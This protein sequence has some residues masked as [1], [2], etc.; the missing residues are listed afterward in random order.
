MSWDTAG[1]G[2]GGGGEWGSG[3]SKNFNEPAN[4]DAGDGF[5]NGG[6]F[7]GGSGDAFGDAGGG[8]VGGGGGPSG[9]CFNCGEEGHMKGDCPNPAKPRPCYNCGEEGHT[10]QECTNETVVREFSGTCRICEMVG[11][12]ATDCP[13]KPPSICK[14]CLEEGHE[15]IGCKNPRKI[16]RSHI[17]DVSGEAAWELIKQ[18]VAERDLDD[19]KDAVDMYVKACPDVTY[20]QLEDAFRSQGVGIFLIAIEKEL[21]LTYTNMDL[22]GHLGKKYAISWRWDPKPRAPKEMDVWPTSPEENMERLAD[23][24]QPTDCKMPKCSNCDE[25]GHTKKSCPQDQMETE[26]AQVKCYNCDEVGHRVRDCPTPRPDKFACRNCKQSGHSSKECPEPRSAEGVECKKC[27][28]VGHFSRDCPQGG[29]GGAC[30][31]CG[32]TGHRKQDCTNEKQLICRNCDAIGHLGKECPL[33]R[34]Y[35]RVKCSNCEEMGHT[36]VRCKQPLK[37]E[38]GEGG[39]GGFNAGGAG[40]GNN[41]GGDDF[42]NNT[43]VVSGGGDQWGGGGGGG[44]AW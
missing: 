10:K 36:K 31:N 28:E 41:A 11:H 19:V 12:R 33:P 44:G 13:S 40:F 1:G 4:G 38:D 6:D 43:E 14:N 27:N 37:V 32:E 29:G 18:G 15:I 30:H 42:G 23:A 39:D 2:G 20:A 34:D 24:G 26:R 16:D 5:N 21:N 25:L 35:S 7:R 17:E 8:G 22:Q 3:P 9:G